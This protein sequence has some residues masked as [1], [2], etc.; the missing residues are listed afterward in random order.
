[1]SNME[2]EEEGKEGSNKGKE[3]APIHKNFSWVHRKWRIFDDKVMKPWFGG[4]PRESIE[5]FSPTEPI[6]MLSS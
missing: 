1:M 5:D 2:K 4:K 6:T 3:N